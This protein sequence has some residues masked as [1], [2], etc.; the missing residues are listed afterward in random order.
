VSKI[1]Q[2]RQILFKKVKGL[3][4]DARLLL[5]SVRHEQSTKQFFLSAWTPA[6]DLKRYRK[7]AWCLYRTETPWSRIDLV[8]SHVEECK[9]SATET[10]QYYEIGTIDHS[11]QDGTLDI[12]AHYALLI[13][14]KVS[15]LAGFLNRTGIIRDDWPFKGFALRCQ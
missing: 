12:I 8:F 13:Q 7:L 2:S 6:Y 9:I 4:H 3:I 11:E 14:L 5:D 1:F 10:H 15:K